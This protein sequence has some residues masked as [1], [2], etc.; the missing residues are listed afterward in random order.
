MCSHTFGTGCWLPNVHKIVSFCPNMAQSNKFH[1]GMC[2]FGSQSLV[3]K[4]FEYVESGHTFGR[5]A[6]KIA[7]QQV[8]NL[9]ALKQYLLKHLDG[10]SI[11]VI[12][13]SSS[14]S[15]MSIFMERN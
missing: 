12:C 9:K 14:K 8:N 7:T 15:G 10:F 5:H 3:P 1:A 4:V 6:I 11:I 2:A 13:T